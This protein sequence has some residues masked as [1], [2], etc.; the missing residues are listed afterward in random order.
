MN[1][2]APNELPAIRDIC[3][4]QCNMTVSD[5]SLQ[6]IVVLRPIHLMEPE[7][8]SQQSLTKPLAST[9]K[10]PPPAKTLRK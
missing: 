6:M 5:L 8:Y 2:E 10:R 1:L 3:L 4:K 9:N 7:T